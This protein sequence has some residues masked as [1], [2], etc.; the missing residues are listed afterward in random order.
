MPSSGVRPH[1][2]T[3]MRR[4]D[5]MSA[6]GAGLRNLHQYFYINS[7]LRLQLLLATSFH[8]NWNVDCMLASRHCGL[9]NWKYFIYE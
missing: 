4:P 2:R 3:M 9:S 8:T 6:G 5:A 1:P 7:K